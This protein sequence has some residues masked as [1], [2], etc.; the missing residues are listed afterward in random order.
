MLLETSYE[1]KT[2]GK[3]VVELAEYLVSPECSQ[4]AAST[5]FIVIE[6]PFLAKAKELIARANK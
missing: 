4:G 3:A 1:D 5:G 2:K 6:G